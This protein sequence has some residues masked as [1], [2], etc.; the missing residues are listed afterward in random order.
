MAR[1]AMNIPADFSSLS[2]MF[3]RIILCY[4]VNS[5]RIGLERGLSVK[6]AVW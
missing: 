6:G 3:V 2:C 4:R 1:V 5:N